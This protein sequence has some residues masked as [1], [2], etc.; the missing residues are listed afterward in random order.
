MSVVLV[1]GVAQLY[2]GDLDAGR[3][4]VERLGTEDLGPDVLVEELSY[5][6]VAVMQRLEDLRPDALVLIGAAQRGRPPGAVERRR[7][8]DPRRTPDEVQTAVWGAVTGYVNID[9]LVDVASGFHALPRRTVA[10]E[11]EP[12]SCEPATSLTPAAEAALARALELVRDEV[13]RAPVLRLAD[14]LRELVGEAR[15]G[16]APALR[17][18]RRLLEELDEVDAR[19][20]WGATFA[21]RDRLRDQIAAGKEPEGMTALDWSLWWA[22]IEELDRR[23]PP[24]GRISSAGSSNGGSSSSPRF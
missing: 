21:L 22:L 2:Q 8:R 4:A 11:I 5:G 24:E 19:G 23:Q 12:V 9:L 18:L 14:E 7:L 13:R 6:A 16:G 10:V 17:T 3:V 20:E 1:G 15:P